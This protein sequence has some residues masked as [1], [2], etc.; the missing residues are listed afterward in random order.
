MRRPA[1][2]CVAGAMMVSMLGTVPVEASDRRS[3]TSA[4]DSACSN[5]AV[6]FIKLD[7]FAPE[8]YWTAPGGQ[9]I[10]W[11]PYYL[12]AEGADAGRFRITRDSD[13][14]DD[15]LARAFYDADTVTATVGSD[16]SLPS[17]WSN[18]LED[19]Y[20][21]TPDKYYQDVDVPIA[22][23]TQAEPVVEKAVVRLTT[24]DNAI[25]GR[26]T[27]APLYI[28]DND[29]SGFAF[30]EPTYTHSEFVPKMPVPVF[31]GGPATTSETV[32]FTVEESGADPAVE[33]E[34]FTV[35]GPKS[36][37][38]GRDE[39]VKVIDIS[40]L[41]NLEADGDRSFKIKLTGE[42]TQDETEVT[43]LDAGG[44]PPVRP[45]SRF[46]H[47]R[48][49]WKYQ[50]SD[51]RIREIHTFAFDDGGPVID[52]ARF[53]LRKKMRSGSC[54]WW[55]GS[56]FKGGNC[57]AK[58]WLQMKRF[59]DFGGKLLYTYNVKKRLEPTQGTRIRTYTGFTK[60]GNI[61]GAAETKLEKGR[62]V[63]NFKV[64]R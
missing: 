64:T 11:K 31:R 37:T 30:A 35:N 59:G 7:R 21:G 15:Q 13:D 53:A 36:V 19:R 58:K 51:F 63:S 33:G 42:T 55:N 52:W 49:G 57:S 2:I 20:H 46:H 23:D 9:Q 44:D 26:E 61:A 3:R 54:S 25:A 60:V 24:F 1:G 14:C 39:R 4:S 22:N 27:Q 48:Q 62:N 40:V 16:F 41:N 38:F 29:R 18:Q 17:A 12:A 43:I 32:G 28:V 6:I 47:P 56:G 50:R 5:E 10:L 45:H 8:A 34:N